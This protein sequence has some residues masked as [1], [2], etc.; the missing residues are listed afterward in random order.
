MFGRELA[1][2]PEQ[3]VFEKP[4]ISN[5]ALKKAAEQH[6][7]L[8]S[9]RFIYKL[10]TMCLLEQEGILDDIYIKDNEGQMSLLV[11]LFEDQSNI[12]VV[13]LAMEEISWTHKFA[14]ASQLCRKQDGAD[15]KV[16]LMLRMRAMQTS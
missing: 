12:E 9:A 5:L 14:V 6:D 13:K 16:S 1:G 4:I 8:L 3:T 15:A 10:L 7:I 2:H 11:N